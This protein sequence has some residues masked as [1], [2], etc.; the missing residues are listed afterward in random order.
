MKTI[1]VFIIFII[2]GLVQLFVPVNMILNQEAILKTGTVYKFK[3]RPVDPNDPFKGKYI[4][5]N[6]Q[7][8]TFETID[9]LW[10]RHDEVYVYL[11]T[12]SL[13]FAKIKKISRDVI[14]TNKNDYI[15]AKVYWYS[16]SDHKLSMA[17]PFNRYYMEESKAENAEKAVRD[18]QRNLTTNTIYALVYIKD[19]Q[20][21]LNDVIL[22]GISIK[23]YL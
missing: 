16:K 9:S 19:G 7:I 20:G 22:D 17:F 5:L 21:V 10:Q 4:E 18:I 11:T 2:V 13:G 1:Y 12:D 14:L 23:D 6:Y 3:T 8:D 15:K